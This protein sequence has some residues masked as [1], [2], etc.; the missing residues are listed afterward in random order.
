MNAL[1]C[2]GKRHAVGRRFWQRLM[3]RMGIALLSGAAHASATAACQQQ[4]SAD[5]YE[6]F[7]PAQ[8]SG[9]MHYYTSQ[10]PRAAEDQSPTRALIVVH[11]HPR[12]ANVT[13]NAALA[14]L[15]SAQA[16]NDTVVIAPVFQ[17]SADE[18]DRCSTDGV[19]AAQANDLRWTCAS[20]ID[21]GKADDASGMTSF[22]AMDALVK[23]VAHRWPSVHEVTIAGFSAGAQM[24][25]HYIG[26]AAADVPRTL[27]IRYVV[28]DPGSWLYFD[29]IRPSTQMDGHTVDTSTCA[30][31]GCEFQHVASNATCPNI[32]QWKYGTESLPAS[33]N[34]VAAA[35]RAQYASADVH[36][37][38]AAQDSGPGRGTYSRILDKTCAAMAQGTFRLQR[39][40]AYAAYD[41]QWLAR[42]RPRAVTVVPGCAHDVTCVFSAPAAQAA[43]LGMPH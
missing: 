4:A 23:E 15:S 9:V 21:G 17:V 13:F 38:E 43:L 22:A 28:A 27:A 19:P 5:C 30:D 36:Y 42:D 33:L 37:L 39:G 2:R 26:F 35:A 20:W 41:R 29:S 8:G 24:V 6:A 40:M 32:N 34:R 7:H 10:R 31:A 25:Q 18:A 1:A 16:L 3:V 14:A 12:D 11:G